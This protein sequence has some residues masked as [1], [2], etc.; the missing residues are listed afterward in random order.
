MAVLQLNPTP[1]I[2]CYHPIILYLYS[3]C[4]VS[5]RILN[6]DIIINIIIIVII[7]WVFS[8]EVMGEN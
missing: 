1:V 4:S 6:K 8:A 3:F 2:T 5:G 7:I